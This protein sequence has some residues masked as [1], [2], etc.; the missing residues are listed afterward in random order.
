MSIQFDLSRPASEARIVVAMSGGVDSS[1]V[2]ALAARTGAEVIGV[3]LQLYDHGEAVKRSGSCCAGQDIY[4][5]AQVCERLGIPHYVLDYESR[6]RTGVIDRFA[7][8]YARGRTP[9]PCSLCNQRVKF[10]DLIDFAHELGADCL[11]TGHYVRRVVNGGRAELHKGA[12][13]RRDQ[14]YFLYGTTAT[15]LDFLRFPLGHLPKDEVR[16][17]AA[18]AG[19]TVAAKPDS[20][21]ICFVPDGDYAG[22]VKR[23]R[24]ET[25][26]P[27]DIVD[28]DGQVLGRHPGVIHFTVGQRRGIELGG[29]A[30]PLYVVRIEPEA[31]RLVVGPRHALAVREATIEDRNWLGEGQRQVTVKVR[32]LAPAVPATIEGDRIRFASPE[33]GVAPGQ[34]AVVYDGDRLLGGGWIAAT[35]PAELA[36]A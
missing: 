16:R 1:V 30:E 14:S 3:T 7:D 24:P 5:A 2:A 9:V 10:T 31:H 22:L 33:Y 6:F 27:G 12:D 17:L 26:T 19:L 13:P 11:A 23:L 35:M 20:Q 18:E 15:Q 8:D 29:R 4:D 28:L 21:D 25:A 32:S 34:A 36:A